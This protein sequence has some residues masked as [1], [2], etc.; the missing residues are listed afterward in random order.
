MEG[1]GDIELIIVGAVGAFEVG[2]LFA[3]S[4]MVL[5]EAA[6]E[7]TDET[8]ELEDFEPAFASELLAVIDGE[9]DLGADAV[10]SE[11]GDGPEI[12]AESVGPGAF[13]GVGHEFKAGVDID[14][15]PLEVGDPVAVEVQDLLTG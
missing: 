11:P 10:R 12:E 5:D 13:S 2:V 15:P 7:G 8:A 14:G 4:F 3:V 9:D 1:A 6:T